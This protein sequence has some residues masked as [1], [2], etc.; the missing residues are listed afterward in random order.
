MT[1]SESRNIHCLRQIQK[2]KNK[3]LIVKKAGYASP[4]NGSQNIL[5]G[6]I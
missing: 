3:V 1:V 5:S 2:I 4:K 6:E